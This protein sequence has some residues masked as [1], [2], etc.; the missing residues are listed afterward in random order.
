MSAFASCSSLD[1]V[2][3]YVSVSYVSAPAYRSAALSV[4]GAANDSVAANVS[5]G[6]GVSERRERVGSERV[7]GERVSVANVSVANVSVSECI[8]ARVRLER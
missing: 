1:S 5:A 3:S 8:G 6:A 4:L 7:G 2:V